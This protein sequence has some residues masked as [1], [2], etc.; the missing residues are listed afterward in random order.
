MTEIATELS[1]ILMISTVATSLFVEDGVVKGITAKN[2]DGETININ[3][4][5]VILVA[6]GFGAN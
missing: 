2:S 6:G 1:A 5:Q 4:K 3:A